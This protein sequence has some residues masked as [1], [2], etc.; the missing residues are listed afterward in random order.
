MFSVT[1]LGFVLFYFYFPE[2]YCRVFIN[3]FGFIFYLLVLLLNLN[4]VFKLLSQK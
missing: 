4:S 1:V 3:P 2:F